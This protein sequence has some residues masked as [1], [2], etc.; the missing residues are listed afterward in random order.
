MC[1]SKLNRVPSIDLTQ[2]IIYPLNDANKE[3]HVGFVQPRSKMASMRC[4]PASNVAPIPSHITGH[5]ELIG[6]KSNRHFPLPLL[7]LEDL[8][9]IHWNCERTKELRR[10]SKMGSRRGNTGAVLEI[11]TDLNCRVVGS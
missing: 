9:E 7:S 2:K 6:R 4:L 10:E 3:R 11:E 1:V 5:W 8:D